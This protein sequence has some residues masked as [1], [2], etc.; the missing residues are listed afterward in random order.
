MAAM[1]QTPKQSIPYTPS[2]TEFQWFHWNLCRLPAGTWLLKLAIEVNSPQ[3]NLSLSTKFSIFINVNYH[4]RIKGLGKPCGFLREKPNGP[5]SWY[6]N[7]R[8]LRMVVSMM[9]GLGM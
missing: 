8:K 3:Q 4:S 9:D 5:T 2:T 1:V 7:E 6:Y